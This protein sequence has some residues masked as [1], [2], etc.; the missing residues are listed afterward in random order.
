MTKLLLATEA[1]ADG[2]VTRRELASRYQMVYRNVYCPAGDRLTARDR[3][4]AAWMWS[5]RQAVVSGASAAA[6]HGSRWIPPDDPAELARTQYRCPSGIVAHTGLLAE[7]EIQ[8]L[9]GIPCTT[10]ARTAYDLGR[11]LSLTMGVIRVD[12]L[13]R[14]TGMPVDEV[15]AIA[16]R[17]PGA[18]HI[19]RLRSVVD[20]T[21]PG[22]ESPQETRLRLVLIGAGL[23]RPSTQI[24]ICDEYGYVVRR[25]DMGWPRYKVG[26]EY[27]GAQHWT[28]ADQHADDIDRLE[29]FAG[30]GW[31]MVRVSA[32]HLRWDRGGIAKRAG[33]ALLARGWDP[34]DCI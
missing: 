12:A 2:I 7:D 19:S 34:R 6:L 5:G 11:R 17:Y 15:R 13:L 25:I 3:A 29:L 9:G 14:A 20:L 16:R 31:R 28:D 22:A 24:P 23:P 27:D 10:P 18:R 33:D 30:L 21:D 1:L 8:R 32:R 4:V 26:V